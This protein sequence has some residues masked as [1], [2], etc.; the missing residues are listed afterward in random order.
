MQ[1]ELC[2]EYLTAAQMRCRLLAPDICAAVKYSEHSSLE[3]CRSHSVDAPGLRGAKRL[4][5]RRRGRLWRR[6]TACCWRR[7]AT[8]RAAGRAWAVLC[9]RPLVHCVPGAAPRPEAPRGRNEACAGWV[10]CVL[11]RARKGSTRRPGPRRRSTQSLF[12]SCSRSPSAGW[13][14]AAPQPA[15][16]AATD[17]AAAVDALYGEL[18]AGARRRGAG[19]AGGEPRL[20]AGSPEGAAALGAGIR[21][22]RARHVAYVHQ[23]H[24]DLAQVAAPLARPARRCRP[25][26]C[27]PTR[28]PRRPPACADTR[29]RAGRAGTMPRGWLG[30]GA[31]LR[32][33]WSM[34][35]T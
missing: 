13:Q 25:P 26:A 18:L 20:A 5:M 6:C 4:S 14:D 31:P 17:V 7:D 11:L 3:S 15:A 10:A 16:A 33:S 22:L 19:G 27:R 23:A 24:H 30:R 28:P 35:D 21:D 1:R 29:A 2:S 12:L 8:Q 9:E 34:Q 32:P